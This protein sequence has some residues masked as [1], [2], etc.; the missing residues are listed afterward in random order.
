DLNSLELDDHVADFQTRFGCG[1]I[2]EFKGIEVSGVSKF[3]WLVA[4]TQVGE[5]VRVRILRDGREKKLD[6]VLAERPD[7]EVASAVEGTVE[8]EGWLGIEVGGTGSPQARQLGI[9]PDEEGVVVLD[10]EEGGPSDDAG[11]RPG[12]I[13]V[14]ID[15]REIGNLR[16]YKKVRDSLKDRD[17]A[18]VFL[19]QRGAYT[20]FLAV[21]PQHGE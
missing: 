15:N 12:D 19:V 10:I 17:K 18:I 6:L 4:D 8:E 20:T 9:D 21:K 11:F 16:D 5:E 7:S 14:E 2:L 3:R 1:R 13:I